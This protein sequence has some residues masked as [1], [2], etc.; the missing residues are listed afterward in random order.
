MSLTAVR[1]DGRL[2]DEL[3]PLVFERGVNRYA[4]GS[5]FVAW[6]D[7][8]VLCTASIEEKIPLF[9]RG[10]GQGWITAEYAMLPR[11]TNTRTIRDGVRGHIGGRSQEIQRLIGRSLRSAV[12][13]PLLG[14]RT[15]WVDCDVLQAD[16]GTRTAAISGASVALADA[17]RLL[18]KEERLPCIPLRSLVSAV[19][20]GK[21]EGLPLLDLRYD[22][23]SCADVDAN[24]VADEE[25][26]FIEVQATGE[27]GTLSRNE[28]QVFLDL[29]D[30]GLSR[31][32]ALQKGSLQFVEEEEE[33]L[34]EGRRR[35]GE[36]QPRQASGA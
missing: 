10:T 6:G 9:L 19:S 12:F 34:A 28:L 26:R 18:W 11:A 14:E 1:V 3:R 35:F 27:R 36:F 17:L 32:R 22:E 2:P 24:I 30:L 5:V 16:G 8:Q 23:D 29:A 13:L 20:V 15:I 4:E 21:V 33:A 25:G 31:I 7:T